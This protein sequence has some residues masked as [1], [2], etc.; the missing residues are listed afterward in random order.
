VI[1][2]VDEPE[3]IIIGAGM[4]D[5]QL[6]DMNARYV[7]SQHFDD[8][9]NVAMHLP[10][11]NRGSCRITG[12]P[13]VISKY[14]FCRQTRNNHRSGLEPIVQAALR[15]S[16][17]EWAPPFKDQVGFSFPLTSVAPNDL[18]DSND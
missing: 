3:A 18:T 6:L 1:V 11:L 10:S 7:R 8:Q 12:N 4:Y 9:I 15:A 2:D 17:M 13:E 5:F 16:R 14:P